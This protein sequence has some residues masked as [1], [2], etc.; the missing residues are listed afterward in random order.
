MGWFSDFEYLSYLVRH[1]IKVSWWSVESL[2]SVWPVYKFKAWLVSQLIP[3]FFLQ[4]GSGSS[5]DNV[6][7]SSWG[8]QV[9]QHGNQ[10][11][12]FFRKNI[13]F[14]KGG[15][16]FPQTICFSKVLEQVSISIETCAVWRD[17]KGSILGKWLC[18]EPQGTSKCCSREAVDKKGTSPSGRHGH[19][20]APRSES[21]YLRR[22]CFH[23]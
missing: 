22:W 20:N 14:S 2:S 16:G 9:E 1:G 6:L 19:G 5:D 17:P 18:L 13:H 8:S 23:R 3:M 12:Q 21:Q 15:M 7:F 10:T 4:G 11:C